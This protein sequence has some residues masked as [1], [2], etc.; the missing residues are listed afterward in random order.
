MTTLIGWV[1]GGAGVRSHTSM[2][3][4]FCVYTLALSMPIS[5]KKSLQRFLEKT[6]KL[7][8][9][10]TCLAQL[11]F[12]YCTKSEL[13]FYILRKSFSLQ[14]LATIPTP[15]KG[16]TM[17]RRIYRTKYCWRNLVSVYFPRL[18]FFKSLHIEIIII[19]IFLIESVSR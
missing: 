19:Q 7:F 1:L 18:V 16:N 15:L 6:P 3:D 13:L 10:V 12:W 14:F 11:D 17:L 2:L 8:I 5:K 9:V 4:T